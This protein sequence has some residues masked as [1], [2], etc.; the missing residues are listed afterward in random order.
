MQE[1]SVRRLDVVADPKAVSLITAH[2]GRLYG[3]GERLRLRLTQMARLTLHI[4]PLYGEDAARG[5]H[6]DLR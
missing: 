5:D 3:P 4:F 1:R 2:G 6:P